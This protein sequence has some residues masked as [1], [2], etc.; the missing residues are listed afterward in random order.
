MGVGG[1]GREDESSGGA[2]RLGWGLATQTQS[3]LVSKHP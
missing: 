3:Y 1:E 2:R